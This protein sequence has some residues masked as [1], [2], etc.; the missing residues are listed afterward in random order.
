MSED[1]P[2]LPEPSGLESPISCLGLPDEIALS[3]ALSPYPPATVGDLL[4]IAR[5]NRL[6]E[7]RGIGPARKRTIEVSLRLAGCDL[8][9]PPGRQFFLRGRPRRRKQDDTAAQDAAR[10]LD[11]SWNP[12]RVARLM[13]PDSS[14]E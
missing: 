12:G 4:A 11:Q 2:M 5:D 13:D 3:L 9:D 7:I 10:L 8:G 6:T 1:P 14:D